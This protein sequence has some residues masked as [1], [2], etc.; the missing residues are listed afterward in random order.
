MGGPRT[1]LCVGIRTNI[2]CEPCGHV[3]C[4]CGSL[5]ETFSDRQGLHIPDD[6]KSGVLTVSHVMQERV[7][8][9]I[10]T[11]HTR[12]EWRMMLDI[13]RGVIKT[14]GAKPDYTRTGDLLLRASDSELR[15]F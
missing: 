11:D 6:W 4:L 8:S 5:P 9:E 10:D 1:P 12:V 3:I 13:E 2:A 14:Q 7:S 15:H